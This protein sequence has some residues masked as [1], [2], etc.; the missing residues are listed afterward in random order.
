M[1]YVQAFVTYDLKNKLKLLGQLLS[2]GWDT[3]DRQPGD[4]IRLIRILVHQAV[5]LPGDVVIS[6]HD[7]EDRVP[8]ENQ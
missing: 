5:A 2:L 6:V 3:K 7:R 4:M 8:D 1:F